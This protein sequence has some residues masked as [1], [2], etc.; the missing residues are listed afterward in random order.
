MPLFVGVFLS[1]L[2][3]TDTHL[4]YL[5]LN[6][7]MKQLLFFSILCAFLCGSSNR[8]YGQVGIGTTTPDA[9]AIL[10]I[11]GTGKGLLIPRMA[12]SARPT[13]PATGLIIYQTDGTAGFYYYDGSA[14]K[15][16]MN[17]T[18]A[19]TAFNDTLI[20][21]LYTSGYMITADGTTGLTVG[22]NGKI[23]AGTL[24]SATGNYSSVLGYSDTASGSS[25]LAAGYF[26]KATGN[27]S[28]SLGYQSTSS[29]LGS[30][31]LGYNN[32]SSGW[33][34]LAAGLFTTS[35][36]T[37]S[38][39]LGS[40][41]SA[42]GTYAFAMGRQVQAS[43]NYSTAMGY[44]VRT[45][46]M[47]GSF[48]F[49]DTSGSSITIND[50]ANQMMMR[51]AGGYKLYSN[52]RTTKGLS[53]DS[54]G[55]IY[56]M[57]NVSGNYTSRSLTDKNYVDSVG[58]SGFNDTLTRNLYTSG[59][60]ITADGSSG[61]TLGSSGKINGSLFGSVTGNYSS[62][63]G[64]SDTASGSY[65]HAAG[66][67][68]K[69]TN[70]ASM[71]LGYQTTA[72][73]Q[74]SLA[75]G[76]NSNATGWGA[77]ATGLYSTS[78]GTASTALG[79]SNTASGD[80]SFAAG[81]Q[82][83]ATGAYSFALGYNVKTNN[84][85]GSFILGDTSATGYTQNDAANQMMMRFAG[86]YKLYS[87]SRTTKGVSID[88]NGV[89]NYM[90]NVSGNYSSRSLTDKNYVDS[91]IS[92]RVT[93]ATFNDTLTRNLYTSG[94]MVTADGTTGLNMYSNGGVL[95]TGTIYSGYYLPVSGAGTRMMWN[96]RSASFR[97]GGVS[98]TQ[99]DSTN[100]GNYSSSF[101]YNNIASGYFS[102][103]TGEGNTASAAHTVVLGYASSAS[104]EG[105]VSL[106]N[107]NTASGASSTTIGR[108]NLASGFGSSAIGYSNISSGTASTTIGGNSTASGDYSIAGG[109]SVTASGKQ[110]VAL[111]SYASTNG[112]PGAF[113]FSDTTTS[114]MYNDAANQMKMRFTGGYKLYSDAGL[115]KGIEIDGNGVVNYASNTSGSYTSRSLTDKN[116]VDSTIS[117]S[118][119]SA[120][121]NDTMTRNLYTSGY[122]ITPDGLSGLYLS[123]L[124]STAS[125]YQSYAPSNYST[126]LGIGDTATG[127]GSVA[128]GNT[129]YASGEGSV[130]IGYNTLSSGQG[131]LAMGSNTKALASGAMALGLH[132]TASGVGSISMGSSNFSTG[133]YS[134]AIGFQVNAT[135][136]TSVA[137]GYNA[138]T[139][140]KTGSFVFGDSS[141][142]F[143]ANDANNQMMMRFS[144][145]Y[146]LYSNTGISKGISIDS[147]GAA[148]Y[149]TNTSGSYT[150][151]SLTDKNYVDSVSRTGFNDTLTRNLY[152][153]GYT[154]TADGSRGLLM[155]ANGS[156]IDS[157][158]FGGG[159][160]F[161]ASGA[162]S[163]MMWSP[164]KASFRAG[165]V[166]GSAWDSTNSG[167]NSFAA[168]YDTKAGGAQA[169]AFGVSSNASGTMSLS[170]GYNSTSAGAASIALGTSNYA[171]GSESVSVGN[172]DSVS[173]SYGF[174]AGFKNKN[175]GEGA[176]VAG[177]NNVV[178][179][180]GASALG[181]SNTVS[182]AYSQAV[183]YGNS[184]SGS[185]SNSIGFTNTA[186]GNKS[187]AMGSN[188][189]TN[190]NAGSFV[191]G[192][193]TTTTASNDTVNQMMMRFNGG[194]KLFSNTAMTQGL[195]IYNGGAAAFGSSTYAPGAAAFA[196]GYL[197]Y[198]SGNGGLAMGRSDTAAGAYSGAMGLGNIVSGSSSFGL[199]SSNVVA[200][201]SSAA[202][203][204]SNTA[205]ATG[206]FAMGTKCTA[207]GL[208]SMAMGSNVSTNAKQGSFIIGDSIST[209]A[210]N[211]AVNQ[212]MMRFVG[213]YKLYSNTG[214]NAG[215]Q[216]NAQGGTNIG[217]S[218]TVS[219]NYSTAIGFTN[220]ASGNKSVAMGSN[221]STA[222]FAGAFIFGDSTAT[223]TSNTAANQMI[224]RFVGG[225]KLY[226]NTGL[227][228]GLQL[229]AQGGANIGASNTVSGN[230]STAIG[231]TNTA[232]GNKSVAMGS[233][234]STAGFAGAFIF[235]DSTAT[236]TSNTAA[237][238]MVGRFVGGYKLYSNTAL[239]AG[240]QLT[241]T[242]GSSIG[243][244]N[245]VSGTNATCVGNTV[246]ASNTN[247]VA[248]GFNATSSGIASMALG[249]YVSTNAKNGACVIG[250]SSTSTVT[251]ASTTNQMTMR[252]AN[253]YRL[254]TNSGATVG[255]QLAAGGNSWSTISDR[256]KKENFADVDGELFLKRIGAMPVSS[257]NYKGQDPAMFRHYGPMAQDFYAA[258]GHDKYG[259]VGNDTTINQADMEGVTF[260][261]VKALEQRTEKLQQENKQ[262]KADMAQMKEAY[263]A[264]LERLEALLTN[265]P[266]LIEKKA[267]R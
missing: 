264:R 169:T 154:I 70:I 235:G 81:R 241:S 9:T 98:G 262:L 10:E 147:N 127:A 183:G 88:S 136:N 172:A 80:Y 162:G 158:T 37:G 142:S 27:A 244:S 17:S 253:G 161:T 255:T 115:T 195:Q 74:N 207:S 155:Q 1:K 75:T 219:G 223:V 188:V 63:F 230:Y 212:M 139:N 33:G 118:V 179:G 201:S 56:Y 5:N 246:T 251:S 213:G 103:A 53:I 141:S 106:G 182:G 231:F 26:T 34:S 40:S 104:Q 249:S 138:S 123:N 242:G 178:A 156:F 87:N 116:Y 60:M 234:V 41:N 133:S 260:I 239:T 258:F 54:N 36:G 163:R 21:N 8:G 28:M 119:T 199:G 218:N 12:S 165:F 69:A 135:G 93:S 134:A 257:W 171:S 42:T 47:G 146:K 153:D 58:R 204:A 160:N 193:S 43:G 52:S 24:S 187:V 208:N 19:A 89:I 175:S 148:S 14:W 259:V 29:G 222:G 190:G 229:N 31:A 68:A 99:W 170:V 150:S 250:D 38:V 113:I 57:N 22:A 44:N 86:G 206:S 145:G 117:A 108:Y 78:S 32:T 109:N 214:L 65:S 267:D 197:S 143:A 114:T 100:I 240:L 82:V 210:S 2:Q 124:G 189:S 84:M 11:S 91:T 192:D 144:G 55:V 16:L 186:S 23:N 263:E 25:A 203:G 140:G 176:F 157:G 200:G 180:L 185:Y 101:G 45:N 50:A 126:A 164:A 236:V 107:Q 191:F 13:S 121:F 216:L 167:V 76:L 66:F 226:T 71:S 159:R 72:S 238:Q 128:M 205:S 7:K 111:G 120:T 35:S 62:A 149:M 233:N 217:A 152:T 15:M 209:V 248:I 198:A 130:S 254:Y 79:S 73:G 59:Y 105:A 174:A 181:V 220:T 77:L 232:S 166:S 6:N 3:I 266:S 173:S 177:E 90:N 102:T 92:A 94:Y 67:G 97:A 131:S 224:G 228:S 252:F 83:S 184:A 225:Y 237:N 46:N 215:L 265:K 51:F 227:T 96:P 95:D 39:A 122:T 20:R 137:M 125:G 151:R 211:D 194:Y 4:F 112:M 202:I 243:I 168:G 221:V 110:S 61:L 18:S 30:T 256:R 196:T 64:Y 129:N 48:I 132:T 85:N 245:T 49:G 247:A 261:A